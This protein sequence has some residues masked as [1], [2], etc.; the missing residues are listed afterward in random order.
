MNTEQLLPCPFCG[1]SDLEPRVGAMVAYVA[2]NDCGA[3]GPMNGP[4]APLVGREEAVAAWNRRAVASDLLAALA[5]AQEV[6]VG[7]ATNVPNTHP[8]W[9]QMADALAR[10][11]GEALP[12]HVPRPGAPR[13]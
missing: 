2:C 5:L 3:D 9:A 12:P 11:R 10:V 7:I 13:R 4:E 1:A 8:V 6:L